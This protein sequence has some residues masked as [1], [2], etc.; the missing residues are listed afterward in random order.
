MC[1]YLLEASI[2]YVMYKTNMPHQRSQ[3]SWLTC[4]LQSGW[5]S[6][7]TSIFFF[8][9]NCFEVHHTIC[10]GVNDVNHFSKQV[11]TG[12]QNAFDPENKQGVADSEI[13]QAA[14]GTWS[15]SCVR[16]F[17]FCDLN[18]KEKNINYQKSWKWGLYRNIAH[19]LTCG[20]FLLEQINILCASGLLSTI[21]PG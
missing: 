5:C 3:T 10:F 12:L 6:W 13:F 1:L 11:T 21:F 7:N 4:L 2:V 20:T 19:K 9:V 18:D 17:F 16:I 15:L 14:F 8:F